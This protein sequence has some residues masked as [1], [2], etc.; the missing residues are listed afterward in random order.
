SLI[1]GLACNSVLGI[2]R[3][4]LYASFNGRL[5][6]LY[7]KQ[8]ILSLTKN[9][10]NPALCPRRFTSKYLC[11]SKANSTLLSSKIAFQADCS[12]V[13]IGIDFASCV[14]DLASLNSFITPSTSDH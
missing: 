7:S 10:V 1:A 6:A 5:H 3:V 13:I 8:S 4:S 9:S 12:S 14:L 11:P 2:G